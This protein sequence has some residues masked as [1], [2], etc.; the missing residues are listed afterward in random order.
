MRGRRV[1]KGVETVRAAPISARGGNPVHAFIRKFVRERD[2]VYLGGAGRRCVAGL[3]EANV[4]KGAKSF[5]VA[6]QVA[7]G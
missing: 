5:V 3:N 2:G 4:A 7:R 6:A 1:F